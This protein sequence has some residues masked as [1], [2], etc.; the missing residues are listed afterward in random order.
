MSTHLSKAIPSGI[1]VSGPGL[2]QHW[3]QAEGFGHYAIIYLTVYKH[4]TENLFKPLKILYY[5]VYYIDDCGYKMA[6]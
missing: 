3:M 5:R 2:A 4:N 1:L 6:H